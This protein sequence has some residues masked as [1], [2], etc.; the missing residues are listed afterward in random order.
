MI[1]FSDSGALMVRLSDLP[2]YERSHLVGK[3]MQP[4]APAAWTAVEKPMEQLRLALI[5]TAGI[6]TKG[7]TAFQF[8]DASYRPI[9][10][11]VVLTDLVMSHSSVN[12]DRTGFLEDVNLVFPLDRLKEAAKRREIGSVAEIHYS[13]MGA[14]LSPEAFEESASQVA[15]LLKQDRVDAVFLTPV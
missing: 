15:G 8:A 6:H 4:L 3:N 1:A 11:D 14:G 10:A 9:S 12:F 5:T 13:F 7:E 2:E